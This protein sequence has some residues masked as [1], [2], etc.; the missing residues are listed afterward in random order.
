MITRVPGGIEATYFL[1]SL[2]DGVLSGDGARLS[3]ARARDVEAG[4]G[5]DIEKID[6]EDV[7]RAAGCRGLEVGVDV[8]RELGRRRLGRLDAVLMEAADGLGLAVFLDG[9][10]FLLEAM[11]GVA[12][13]VGDGDVDDGLAGVDLEGR[14]GGWGWWGRGL[15]VGPHLKSEIW[16]TQGGDDDEG[17][18]AETHGVLLDTRRRIETDSSCEHKNKYDYG[19]VTMVSFHGR[20]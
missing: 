13:G 5:G 14:C 15:R 6:E 19:C 12:L 8:G 4:H 2:L 1:A 11:N 7:D 17:Q 18:L 9:E 10:V 20:R 3:V 16:G